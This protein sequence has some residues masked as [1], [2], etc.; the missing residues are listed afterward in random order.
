MVKVD[1]V[2]YPRLNL[3]QNL[4][5]SSQYL[6]VAVRICNKLIRMTSVEVRLISRRYNELVNYSWAQFD[7]IWYDLPRY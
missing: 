6:L 3:F 4:E 7:S 5:T 1:E 2:E